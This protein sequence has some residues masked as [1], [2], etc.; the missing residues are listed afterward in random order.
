VFYMVCST[1]CVI[2]LQMEI[3]NA[4]LQK[5]LT[6]SQRSQKDLTMEVC[7]VYLSGSS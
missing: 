6:A 5:H 1:W 7:S 3:G 2:F 4:E